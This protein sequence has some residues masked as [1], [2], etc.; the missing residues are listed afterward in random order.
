MYYDILIFIGLII[1][2]IAQIGVSSSYS[3]YKKIL[4]SKDLTGFDIARQILDKYYD[5]NN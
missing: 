2:L 3:K 4:N 1:S 5:K